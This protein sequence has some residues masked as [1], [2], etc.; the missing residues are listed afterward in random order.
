MSHL[1]LVKTLSHL[2]EERK[3]IE[4]IEVEGFG[5]SVVRG[6]VTE[7]SGGPSCG[8]TSFALSLLAKLTAEGEIC[9]AVDAAGGFDPCTATQAG[10]KLENLLWIKCGGDIE[11]AFMSADYLVQAKGFGAIWLDLSNLPKEKLRMVPKTYWFRFRTR[12]K[13]TPTIMLAT[14]PEHVTGSASQG[15]FV[16]EREKTEWSGSGKFRLL[17]EFRLRMHEGKQLFGKELRSRIEMDYSE[18]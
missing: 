3:H 5:L 8:K 11:K 2:Q 12:I 9:A 10:V 16:F 4:Q 7:I 14:A 6:A 1:A 15:T 18:I 13:E 17:R